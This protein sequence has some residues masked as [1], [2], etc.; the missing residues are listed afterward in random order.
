MTCVLSICVCSVVQNKPK[1]VSSMVKIIEHY[2]SSAETISR[3][4][5]DMVL[6]PLVNQVRDVFMF[7]FMN[8]HYVVS[9]S[10]FFVCT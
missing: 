7:S 10:A 9:F 2:L 3:D 4:I 8:L 5:L 6:M 1:A